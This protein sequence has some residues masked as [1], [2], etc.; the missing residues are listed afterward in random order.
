[1]KRKIVLFC[2]VQSLVL[3]VF[4]NEKNLP[5]KVDYQGF[6]NLTQEAGAYR[7]TR[8][9]PIQTFLKM[10]EDPQTL[11]LDTR[12]ESAYQRKH[13][14]NAVHLNFSDFT[15]EKLNKLIPNTQTRIL[16]Y[17]N[18]NLENDPQSFPTKMAPLALN[19]PTFINLYGYGYRNIYEL[20]SL[21]DIHDPRLKF[22]GSDVS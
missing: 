18:N 1:M 15:Q 22:E 12:S 7:Q 20:S 16:I 6:Q 9:I 19:I 13:F 14:K 11:I 2:L 5:A 21:L 17:C 10:A 8:L 3:P 4:A